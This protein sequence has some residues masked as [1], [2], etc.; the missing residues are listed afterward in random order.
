MKYPSLLLELLSFLPISP[1]RPCRCSLSA[2]ELTFRYEAHH[3]RYRLQPAGSHTRLASEVVMA[4]I[5]CIH[6]GGDLVHH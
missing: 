5:R 1:A 4:R 6:F 3:A 2:L